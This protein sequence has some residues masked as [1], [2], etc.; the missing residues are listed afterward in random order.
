MDDDRM[1][2]LLYALPRVAS[3]RTPEGYFAVDRDA[4]T[5]QLPSLDESDAWVVANDGSV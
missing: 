1:R 4:A 3:V 5:A 2:S